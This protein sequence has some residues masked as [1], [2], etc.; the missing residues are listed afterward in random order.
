MP[1][2]IARLSWLLGEKQRRPDE[3][4]RADQILHRIEDGLVA[5]RGVEAGEQ[6]MRLVA[7]GAADSVEAF[8]LDPLH[9]A[10]AAR[11]LAGVEGA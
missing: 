4:I 8:A 7:K 9:V 6:E 3:N 11:H 10:P 2:D 5:H 1:A